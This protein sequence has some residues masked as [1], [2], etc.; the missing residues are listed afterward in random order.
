MEEWQW[1]PMPGCE[2]IGG[3]HI[4]GETLSG[5][6]GQVAPCFLPLTIVTIHWHISW[7]ESLSLEDLGKT[8]IFSCW[9]WSQVVCLHRLSASLP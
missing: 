4:A 5:S 7:S 1:W 8:M 9:M 6:E 3:G 2:D